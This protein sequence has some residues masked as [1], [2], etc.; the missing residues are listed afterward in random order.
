MN[1]LFKRNKLYRLS[2][3]VMAISVIGLPASALAQDND[4]EVEEVVVTGSYI[5]N[6]AFAQEA[7]VATVS[8]EDLYESGAPSIGQY[9]RDLTFTQNTDTVAN[10]NA[11]QDGGQDSTGATFNLR[12]L[13]ENS[14]LVL[15]DGLRTVSSTVSAMFPDIA[16]NR[17]EVVLDGGSALYGSDAVAGVVNMIPI[18]DFDGVKA[19]T[20]YQRDEKAQVEDYSA[21]VLWGK[22]FDNGIK[23]VG[24]LEGKHQ[25]SLMT[26][27]RMR[28][29]E[30]AYG[31][32]SSGNPGEYRRV[33]GATPTIGG[34][35]G[36]RIVGSSLRDPSCGTFGS[37]EEQQLG[38]KLSGPSGYPVGSAG[39]YWYYT[40][41]WDLQGEASEYNLYNNAAW[42]ATDWLNF[43][44]TMNH[45]FRK[46]QNRNTG[47]YGQNTNSRNALVVPASHPANPYG[48][49][50]VPYNYRPFT[51]LDPERWPSHFEGTGARLQ[52]VMYYTQR[53][54]LQANFDMSDTWSGY[55]VYSRQFERRNS[56]E[57]LLHIGKMQQALLGQGGPNGN[58][59]WNPF[60]SADP[61]SPFYNEAT[62]R[63]SQALVD[64]LFTNVDNVTTNDDELDIF[65]T[66]IAGEL[67]DL[68]AGPLQMATGFQMRDRTEFLGNNPLELTRADYNV[69]IVDTPPSNDTYYN[70]VYAAFVELDIPILETLAAQVAVR[71]EKF[72]DFGLDATTPKVA[73]R[74]EATPELA[75]RASWGES[76]LAPTATQARPYDPNEGC[77]EVFFGLD[78]ITGGQLTGA[79]GCASGNPNLAPETSVMKNIGFTWEPSGALDGLSVSLDY[80]T[81]E[82]TDRIR[83]LSNPETTDAQFT[84]MLQAIGS[85]EAAYSST[86][87]SA[88]RIAADA[89][90]RTQDNTGAG[91]VIRDLNNNGQVL[92]IIRQANNISSVW[93]D[94][95]DGKVDYRFNTDNWGTFSTSVNVS[96]YSKYEYEDLF[97]G[98]KDALGYQNANSGVVPPLPKVKTSL[99]GS[100]FMGNHSASLTGSYLHNV[101][102]DD[103]VNNLFSKFPA[104]RVIEGQWVVNGQYSYILNDFFGSEVTLSGG[105]RNLFNQQPQR[106]PILGGFESRLQQP[107]GRQ[108]WMSIDWAPSF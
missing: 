46:V 20:Y 6:S 58:E 78:K 28:T 45:S 79:A 34:V 44:L 87:G 1:T 75:I 15:A 85:T 21:S 49:D 33:N 4:A 72:R 30:V 105:I 18:K 66:T 84:R 64:W 26:Y 81:I 77:S 11:G 108:I 100:W 93:I 97:G 25:G 65:E 5:R 98:I 103:T 68:P 101:L 7:N 60:G 96:Y 73:L 99:R 52:P 43:E 23:Y 13:G 104:D 48:F 35:H 53:Y 17:L 59:Y 102:F 29:A 82:Y 38:G 56:D 9:I 42:E 19:R 88:T 69:N 36:G 57:K 16:L 50:V 62:T 39:C 24:A 14:T 37:P 89:W 22:S 107:W 2:Q 55:A 8:Q 41:Q 10:V 70:K 80:Q 71:H 67:F 47:T 86:P 3:A 31:Y 51:L 94:L 32:S 63:N 76:F 91:G 12:G 92:R 74:W 90:L 61:R 95:Y 40:P 54:K 83:T 106:L 27:E